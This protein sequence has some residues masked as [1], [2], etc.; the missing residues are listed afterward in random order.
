MTGTE[1]PRAPP[2]GPLRILVT[3]AGGQLGRS[4]RARVAESPPPSAAVT[5]ADRTALD[6]TRADRVAAWLDR[7]PA[8]VVINAAAYTAVDRAAA[9]YGRA[10]AANAEAP[11]LLAQACARRGA[12]LVHVS[13]DYVFDGRAGR[14][15]T[16]DDPVGPLNAY[17]RS[18]LEGERQVLELAPTSLVLRC[19]WIFSAYGGNFV[20]TM[21][22]L[23]RER[24]TLQVVDDQIGGPTWA[25]DLAQVLL[26]LAMQRPAPAGI[27]HFSGAPWVSWHG[28]AHEILRQAMERG[29]LERPP[30]LSAI[31]TRDRPPAEPR[32]ADSRL[33]GSKLAERLGGRPAPDWRIGLARTLDTLAQAPDGLQ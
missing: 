16:E 17:G 29:L 5:F 6:V 19:G 8:D 18:K 30:V 2:S 3:G 26:E 9:E 13:T 22:R 28:F 31:A 15:Y 32:P 21:L 33:D 11:G 14:P 12:R 23:G 25:G 27:Y 7:H 10:L 1:P 20:K 24:D 4:L